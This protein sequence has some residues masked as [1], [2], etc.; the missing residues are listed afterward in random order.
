ML[1]FLLRLFSSNWYGLFIHIMFAIGLVLYVLGHFYKK[2]ASFDS[3]GVLVGLLDQITPYAIM[4]RT[5]GVILMLISIYY[6]G[7]YNS[8]VYWKAKI[9]SLAAQVQDAEKRA[10]EANAQIETKIIYR[11][12]VVT[13]TVQVEKE[14]LKESSQ[15]IDSA[16]VVSPEAIAIINSAAKGVVK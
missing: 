4:M 14:K 1:M 6:E 13:K 7:A 16:C 12:K 8:D 2:V 11:T 9:D 15:K 5:V 10:K 3:T